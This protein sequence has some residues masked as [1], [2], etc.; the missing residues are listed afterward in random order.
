[1]IQL[2]KWKWHIGAPLSGALLT[3]AFA[4]HD[5][6]YFALL[7]LIFFYS[8]CT[9]RKVGRALRLGYLFGLGF[10]GSGIWWVF[11]SIHDFGG[12]D[13]F[14]SCVLTVLLIAFLAIFPAFTAGAVAKAAC[15][16]GMPSSIWR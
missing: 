12:A 3:L 7:A 6:H 14:S 9:A 8:C 16:G 13:A 5:L 11:I 2:L 15:I 1:M 4:P 10:F